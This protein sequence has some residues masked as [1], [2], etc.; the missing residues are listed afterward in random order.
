MLEAR[1]ISFAYKGQRPIYEGFDLAVAPGERVALQAPSGFGKTTLCQMLAGYLRPTAGEV[2]VDG[3]PLPARGVCPVQ[4]V[5]QHPEVA[6]DPR[7]R[8]AASLAEA[9]VGRAGMRSLD[10]PALDADHARLLRDLGIRDAWLARY[11]HELSGG[12]LQRFCIAR[13]LATRP[14]YLVA[15][16]IST[17]LDAVTQAHIWHV[18][19]AEVARRGAGM[20]FVSHSPAL[21]ARIATRVVELG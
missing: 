3:R 20:V 15:D 16:E 10:D 9:G 8:M 6:I 2:L 13:A 11:P 4:M 12:E 7:M 19:L 18:L 5:W 17:M 1:G 21:T 14:L